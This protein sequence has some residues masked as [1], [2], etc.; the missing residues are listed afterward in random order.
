M[1]KPLHAEDYAGFLR[2]LRKAR[3][4]RGMTQE[5]VAQA[6][7]ERQTYVS[8]VET[9][10]RRLDIVELA[11]WLA[12]LQM[13]LSEFAPVLESALGAH[14]VL[15]PAAKARRLRRPAGRA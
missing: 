9:G 7:G 5:D 3:E 14:D 1:S 13:T 6:M 12:A 11:R 2:E 4:D 8:K 10:V 15:K